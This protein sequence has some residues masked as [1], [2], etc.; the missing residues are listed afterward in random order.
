MVDQINQTPS[1]ISILSLLLSFEAHRGAILKI[2]NEAHFTHDITVNQFDK[3]VANITISSCLGFSNDELPPE[4]H[5][6][7]KALHISFKCQGS[8]ILRVLVDT[9]S[10]LN[11]LPKNTPR[12]LNIVWELP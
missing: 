2:L 11:F 5:N 4:G 7:N 9:G 8:L 10:S 12:K 3:V 6:H 1:K